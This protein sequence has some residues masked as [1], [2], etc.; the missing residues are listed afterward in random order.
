MKVVAD[1][2]LRRVGSATWLGGSPLRLF[3][4][5]DRGDRILAQLM[6]SGGWEPSG[7]G[8][9]ALCERLADAG[10]VH[11][12]PALGG[13]RTAGA[14]RDELTAV[15][16][17]RDDIGGLEMLLRGLRSDHLTRDLRIVV[18]DDGS[19]DQVEVASVAHANAAT[20]LRHGRAR[21]PAAARNSGLGDVHT[22]L[23]VFIDADVTATSGWLEPLLAHMQDPGTVAVAPR[24]VSS[25]QIGIPDVHG[26][27]PVVRDRS[28]IRH[29]LVDYESE[30]GALDMGAEPA[31]VAVRSR[32]SYVPT[33]MLVVRSDAVRSIGGFDESLR[34]GEDVDLVWRLARHGGTV[35]YEPSSVVTHRPRGGLGGWLSQRVNYGSSAARLEQRH[36]GAVAPVLVS[37]WSAGVWIAALSGHPVLGAALGAGSAIA[38]ARKLGDVEPRVAIDLALRGH[39]DAVREL[40]RALIRPW[41][42]LTVG[43]AVVSRRAR[44]VLVV[45][46]ATHLGSTPGRPVTRA[47]AL[48]DDVAYSVGVW[49]GALGTGTLA[50]LKPSFPRWP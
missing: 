14:V 23:V 15:V 21:G 18:V 7:P 41:W 48:L 2:T 20:V 8:E 9:V 29:A 37:P 38:L 30:H 40:T 44:R 3:R 43:A 42:P 6:G 24:V 45:A 28:G 39:L 10:A 11:P 4:L 1:T 34:F 22:P 32:V 25:A 33:A 26:N 50:V 17:V 16:P 5:A 46:V 13:H 49:Q 36:P 12:V 35:R 47:L 31:R 19:V 27:P